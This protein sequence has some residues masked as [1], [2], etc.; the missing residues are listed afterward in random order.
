[1]ERARGD[2]AVHAEAGQPRPQLA[3]RLAGE[4][5]G[6]HVLGIERVRRATGTRCDG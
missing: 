4:G 1:M 3:G 5:D 6:E 2:V